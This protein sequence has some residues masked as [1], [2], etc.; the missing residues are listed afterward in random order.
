VT[1]EWEVGRAAYRAAV[2]SALL[3]KFCPGDQIKRDGMG[4]HLELQGR[5][6]VCIGFWWENLKE[7]DP[8]E[9]TGVEGKVK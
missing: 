3:A 6:K 4:G 9:G 8:W 2:R 7:R 5:G 1:R